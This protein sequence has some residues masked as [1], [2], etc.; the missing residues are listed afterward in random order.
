M[1]YYR[2]SDYLTW[3]GFTIGVP[4]VFSGMST[5][6]P[7]RGLMMILTT[8]LIWKT[9]RMFGTPLIG[10]KYWRV[11]TGLGF[12]SGFLV[13][14]QDSCSTIRPLPLCQIGDIDNRTFLGL[15]R[16]CKRSENG[17]G[18]DGRKT[19]CWGTPLRKIPNGSLSSRSLRLT[20][21]LC[22]TQISYP[23]PPPRDS[24]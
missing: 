5:P 19:T 4:L 24:D 8:V 2:P 14:Y 7:P 9:P 16:K 22:T 10:G 1:R 17:Y 21:P 12:T 13:S 15:D 20:V 23:S 11:T 3:A 6:H 18:R